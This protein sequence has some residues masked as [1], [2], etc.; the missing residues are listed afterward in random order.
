M[1]ENIALI[2]E[3]ALC[4]RLSIGP[5]TLSRL[6]ATH[7]IYKPASY[8]CGPASRSGQQGDGGAR[9]TKRWLAPDQVELIIAV[10]LGSM[11]P[12]EAQLELD[13]RIRRLGIPTLEKK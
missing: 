1:S 13:R 7:T 10:E 8:K 4:D 12:D 3:K 6:R 2:D 9:P 5:T 11:T